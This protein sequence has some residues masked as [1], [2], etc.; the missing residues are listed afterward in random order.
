MSS[1]CAGVN[2]ELFFR[3]NTMMLLDDAKKMSEH[4][5]KAP[6]QS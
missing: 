1:G 5:V 4:I 6:E 3:D 2:N